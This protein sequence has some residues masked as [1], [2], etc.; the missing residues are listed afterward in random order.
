MDTIK[1]LLEY[2]NLNSHSTS[3]ELNAAYKKLTEALNSQPQA[4]DITKL[5]KVLKK[6]ERLTATNLR[7]QLKKEK[8]IKGALEFHLFKANKSLRVLRSKWAR[9]RGLNFEDHIRDFLNYLFV[10]YSIPHHT[11]RNH[12]SKFEAQPFDLLVFRK[13]T[14]PLLLEC[15]AS[16]VKTLKN[17]SIIL[18]ADSRRYSNYDL[19]K[20]SIELFLSRSHSSMWYVFLEQQ[21]MLLHFVPHDIIR[22]NI[23][24]LGKRRVILDT[25]SCFSLEYD[26]ENLKK[27]DIQKLL[28][29]FEKTSELI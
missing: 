7:K 11:Y 9:K 28:S 25:D 6:I 21:T 15:K 19:K 1:S 23:S 13:S 5:N 4:Q 18:R 29:F 24:T 17:N 20:Q 22:R 26:K 27:Q 16:G 10:K 8:N 3:E 14:F 12:V 2:D